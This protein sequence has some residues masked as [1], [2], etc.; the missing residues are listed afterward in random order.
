[1]AGPSWRETKKTLETITLIYIIY[2]ADG[3]DIY[4]LNHRNQLNLPVRNYD[5]I[6]TIAIMNEIF[7]AV[8]FFGDTSIGTRLNYIL[9]LYLN[10]LG[11]PIYFIILNTTIKPPKPFNIIVITDDVPSDDFESIII[12]ATKRLDILNI[13]L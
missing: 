1:M 2:N 12:H 8:K 13:E 10:R 6:T 7:H 9:K 5:K 4:F 3:I 11:T